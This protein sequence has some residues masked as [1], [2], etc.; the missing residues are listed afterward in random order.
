M[1]FTWL[2]DQQLPPWMFAL[3]HILNDGWCLGEALGVTIQ[4]ERCGKQTVQCES[5][6]YAAEMTTLAVISEMPSS[7]HGRIERDLCRMYRRNHGKQGIQHSNPYSSPSM[8]R[9]YAVPAVRSRSSPFQ[10]L[11]GGHDLLGFFSFSPRS[12]LAR[13]TD[14]EVQSTNPSGT[15]P[16][17]TKTKSRL[18][19]GTVST[20]H[21]SAAAASRWARSLVLRAF[22]HALW[23]RVRVFRRCLQT[24]EKRAGHERRCC[25]SVSR[26]K[27]SADDSLKKS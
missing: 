11:S 12:T 7:I 17:F 16:L 21:A 5:T 25:K 3:V 6:F 19:M 14:G 22:W 2:Q 8:T 27:A 9:T 10:F 1:V 23:I 26:A 20:R 15:S 13:P 24:L 4:R 18:A